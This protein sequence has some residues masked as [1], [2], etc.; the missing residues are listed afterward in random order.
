MKKLGVYL[1]VMVLL[2]CSG[3]SS[4]NNYHDGVYCKGFG[5]I[6]SGNEILRI[7]GNEIFIKKYSHQ[8]SLESEIKLECKQFSDRIELYDNGITRIIRADTGYLKLNDKD[9]Y[10]RFAESEEEFNIK[11]I[12]SKPL[13]RDNKDGTMTLLGR[14]KTDHEQQAESSFF[15]EERRY[16]N[17][18]RAWEYKVQITDNRITLKSYPGQNNE[19]HSDKSKAIDSYTGT[20]DNNGK[21]NISG[22]QEGIE[23]KFVKEDLYQMNYE[24]EWNKYY[25]VNRKGGYKWKTVTGFDKDGNPIIEEIDQ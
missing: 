7:V 23:F 6:G 15:A 4:G 22:N 18:F 2:S 13:V 14:D 16:I 8:G 10:M 5:V 21:I 1:I 17:E 3:I 20:I 24:G 11:E 25:Y 12:A 19:Y 9:I